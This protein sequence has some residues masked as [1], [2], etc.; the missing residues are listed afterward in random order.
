MPRM[1][2]QPID[3]APKDGRV[4]ILANF[5]EACIITGAPHVWAAYFS[6]ADAEDPWWGVSH[7]GANNNGDPTH[8]IPLPRV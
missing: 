1:E 6:D 3:T 8:W 7:A 5:E 2:W 4:I